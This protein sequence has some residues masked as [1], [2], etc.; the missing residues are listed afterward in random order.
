MGIVSWIVLGLI[1]GAIAKFIMPGDDPG[2]YIAA[3]RR[4]CDEV[5]LPRIRKIAPGCA[6]ETIPRAGTPAL[7]VERDSPAEELAR[8]REHVAA[9]RK[10]FERGDTGELFR[11]SL[12]F[13]DGWLKAVRNERLSSTIT[14]YSDQVLLVRQATMVRPDIQ[15]AVVAGFETILSALAAHDSY[16]FF[17]RYGGL[18]VT[19]LV[20]LLL[21]IVT[22]HF[23]R[24]LLPQPRQLSGDVLRRE[25]QEHLRWEI[26]PARGGP[27]YGLLQRAAYDA[28]VFLALP[29]LV[30]T[31]MTMSPALSAAF[32]FLL[33]IFGGHQSARTLHFLGFAAL[34]LFLGVHVLM[35]VLSGFRRQMRGMTIGRAS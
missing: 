32:P 18:V 31:G 33:T 23:R 5:V 34:M 30:L 26:P 4:Q 12:L 25:V 11:A 20:Y 15:R 8:L 35:V 29:L 1:A 14:R 22:G 16:G 2:A 28:V 27:D 19:G 13:R 17:S 9:V 24:H 3:F 6:I 21:G 7:K 10:A